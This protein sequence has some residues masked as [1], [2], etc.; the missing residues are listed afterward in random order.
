LLSQELLGRQASGAGLVSD[1]VV[2]ATADERDVA[3]RE[4][5]RR[6]RTAEP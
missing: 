1:E 3:R 4:L 5:E 2:G 6:S